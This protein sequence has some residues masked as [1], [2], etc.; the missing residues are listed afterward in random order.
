[1]ILRASSLNEKRLTVPLRQSEV[2]ELEAG[3]IVYLDGPVFT[4]MTKWH[5][6][7]IDQ[8]I[9]PPFEIRNAANVMMH[10]GP[11][12][13]KVDGQYRI[14]ALSPLVSMM[15]GRWTPTVLERFG[16]KAII[17]KS[18]MQRSVIERGFKQHRAVFL[19]SIGTW[20]GAWYA[21]CVTQIRE[22]HWLD[23]SLPEAT[24]V[25]D[26]RGFGPFLVETD[27][28]GRSFYE[29]ANANINQRLVQLLGT[30]PYEFIMKRTGE[31]AITDDIW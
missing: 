30:A 1:M 11:A 26:V 12:V 17:G 31:V 19:L 16:V 5:Q 20:I 22:I 23:L 9:P 24:W 15:F 14:S 18:G 7:A 28:R 10:V 29:E 8:N 21:S 4:A 3:D 27:T 13:R 2:D 6:R 25:M